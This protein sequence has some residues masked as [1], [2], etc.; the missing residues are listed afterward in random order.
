[1]RHPLSPNKSPYLTRKG[2]SICGFTLGLGDP[3]MWNE[4]LNVGE[5]ISDWTACVDSNIHGPVHSSISGSWRREGQDDDSPFC[6]QWYGYIAPPTPS[7]LIHPSIDPRYPYGTFVNPYSR[8]C[9][10]CPVCDESQDSKGCM[11]APGNDDSRCGPLW[12]NLVTGND[13]I[14][15]STF[16]RKGTVQPSTTNTVELS[17]PAEIQILGDIGDPAASPN[18]PL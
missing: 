13:T 7:S 3:K 8:G 17:D 12:T 5:H 4:C 10:V 6:A 14:T 11:C 15:Q 2:G 18:D 16:L 1:M 9:F